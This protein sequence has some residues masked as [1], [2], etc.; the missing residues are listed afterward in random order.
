MANAEK[1]ARDIAN[2][3]YRAQARF[4]PFNSAHEGYA[5][6]L[7]ELDELWEEV[8]NN[9]R[10]PSEYIAAMRTEAM[11]LGAMALRFIY[12][13]CDEKR[14]S[15]SMEWRGLGGGYCTIQGQHRAEDCNGEHESAET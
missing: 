2:E 15:Q 11:Q 12:E 4:L 6:I 10:D 13:V 8:K 3:F 7:E 1:I 14:I 5:V 9:K